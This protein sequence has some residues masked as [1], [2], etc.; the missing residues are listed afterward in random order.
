LSITD[1]F[2]SLSTGLIDTVYCTPLAAI[3]LQWFT[4]THYM[5]DVPMANGI[6]GL[7]VSNRFFD[8]LP[9]DLKTLLAETGR[10]T[11]EK[12]IAATRIDNAKSIDVLKQ[13]GL[14]FVMQPEQVDRQ[15]LLRMRDEA[16]SELTTSG[17]I[18]KDLYARTW[19]ALK[20]LRAG[21]TR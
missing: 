17:Y 13:E 1:V 11:S 3:A 20:T 6:G 14:K 8:S 2:T 15:E 18:P 9:P 10:E 19:D 4:K 12:L 5:T 7:I 21:Q 16:A